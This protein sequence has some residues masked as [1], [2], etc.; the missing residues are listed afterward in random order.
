MREKV[1]IFALTCPKYDLIVLSKLPQQH[2]LHK[3]NT[4]AGAIVSTMRAANYFYGS[5]VTATLYK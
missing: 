5:Y 4:L 1:Y 2:Q 3:S